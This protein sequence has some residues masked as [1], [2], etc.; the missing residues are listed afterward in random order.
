MRPVVRVHD[1]VV[2]V[3][4]SGLVFLRA[5]VMVDAEQD[6]SGGL[7]RR[8]EIDR[9]LPAPRPDLDERCRARPVAPARRAALNSAVPSSS[10]MKP[11]AARAWVKSCSVRCSISS[12]F[13]L[14]VAH[15]VAAWTA[16]K[17]AK[18][19]RMTPATLRMVAR[20]STRSRARPP[21]TPIPMTLTR[22]T[23]E[24]TKTDHAW[25]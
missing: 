19:A 10:G 9:R 15:P 5:V 3:V 7:G 24:P 18:P 21:M 16:V 20:G 8:A 13:S 22:A 25:W 23:A 1:L 2:V 11:L 12:R 4:P 17:I 6:G 14:G